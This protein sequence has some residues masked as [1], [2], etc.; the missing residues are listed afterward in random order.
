MEDQNFTQKELIEHWFAEIT[1]RLDKQDTTM[2]S[3]NVLLNSIQLQTT[4]T[5]GRVTKLEFWNSAL[6]WTCG[7]LWTLLL[8]LVPILYHLEQLQSVSDS[9][10]AVRDVLAQYNIIYQ[11]S[12]K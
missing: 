4:R 11:P 7:V 1:R 5:N 6:K 9:H 8:V 12:S 10:K 2:E 3:Q